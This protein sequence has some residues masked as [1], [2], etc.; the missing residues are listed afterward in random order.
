MK[1]YLLVSFII[2]VFSSLAFGVATVAT[3]GMSNT[4]GG[5]TGTNNIQAGETIYISGTASGITS[6]YSLN[7][8]LDTSLK[9]LI[10]ILYHTILIHL[11]VLSYPLKYLQKKKKE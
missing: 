11:Q 7:N 2:L 4:S 6:N 1:K 9:I 10:H 8:V 5:G 3:V